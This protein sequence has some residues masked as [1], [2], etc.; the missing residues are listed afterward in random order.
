MYCTYQWQE[1]NT[2]MFY[3]VKLLFVQWQ[4]C[5]LGMFGGRADST[6]GR[7][8]G[9]VWVKGLFEELLKV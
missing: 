6:P 4:H 1:S 7:G 5:D 3:Y 8:K 9:L 2:L